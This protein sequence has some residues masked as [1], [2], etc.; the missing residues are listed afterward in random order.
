ML[1]AFD[2]A[3]HDLLGLKEGRLPRHAKAYAD[4]GAETSRGTKA[5]SLAG[6]IVNGGLVEVPMGS[7][8]RHLIFDVGGVLI[9]THDQSYR[10]KWE[11]RLGLEPGGAAAGVF[12]AHDGVVK[13]QDPRR[14]G[15]EP[16]VA[17][18]AHEDDRCLRAESP[19]LRHVRSRFVDRSV[20][21]SHRMSRCFADGQSPVALVQFD[22]TREG[23]Q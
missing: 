14:L 12:E 23:E 21:T 4:L 3:F 19:P 13:A 10:R 2:L 6:K 1:C 11:T 9:R 17:A 15:Q 16:A 20:P 18:P 7:S 5:F 22:D 8:L